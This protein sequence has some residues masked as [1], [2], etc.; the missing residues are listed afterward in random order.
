[1]KK[2]IVFFL[3]LVCCPV[4]ADTA[5]LL[6]PNPYMELYNR[7]IELERK[8]QAALE[9]E[10]SLPNRMLGAV[11]IGATG[12]GGMMTASAL[13]EHRADAAA[14]QAMTAYLE[15][16]T[17]EYGDGKR[18]KGGETNIELPGGND[19][20]ALYTEYAT[21][22]NDLKVRKDLLGLAPGIESEVVVDKADTGLYDSVG[23][24][25]TGGAYASIARAIMN[26][27]GEDAKMWAE[28]KAQ[29][30]QNLKIGTGVAG[31]GAIGGMVGNVAIN[32]FDG[33]RRGKDQT[34]NQQ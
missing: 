14:E 23:V 11:S 6:P 2:L 26:P 34:E 32:G 33:Q 5:D 25:I 7:A 16:I 28:Q 13:A 1:M 18:V 15:T 19:M 9:K 10:Q 31:A 30:E 4:F 29:T 22:A 8:Y 24:G 27:D 12:I 3:L 21:L 17:C 20:I